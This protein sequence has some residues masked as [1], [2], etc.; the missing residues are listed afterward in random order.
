M[1]VLRGR[2]LRP[3]HR[4]P[5]P[6]GGWH[7]TPAGALQPESGFAGAKLHFVQIGLGTFGTFIQNLVGRKDEWDTAIGWLLEAVS[8]TRPRHFLGAAVEPVPEH[9]ERLRWQA[10]HRL[11]GLR[12]VQAAI[13]DEEG[14]MELTVLTQAAHDKALASAPRQSRAEVEQT[15]LYL[16]NMSHLTG[17]DNGWHYIVDRAWRDWGADVQPETLRTEVWSYR[18]LAKSLD[19]CG[20][21]VLAIDAEGYDTKILR[22]VVKHCVEEEMRGRCAWPDLITFE[23]AGHCDSI[24]GKGAEAAAIKQLELCGYTN[25]THNH[26]NTYMVRLQA[27]AQSWP[28]HRWLGKMACSACGGQYWPIRY[29]SG[30]PLCSWCS[31]P[32]GETA[33]ETADHDVSAGPTMPPTP[34]SDNPPLTPYQHKLRMQG[35]R[36]AKKPRTDG[37]DGWWA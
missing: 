29:D 35:G 11:P 23:S 7:S 19:F 9:A 3:S 6:G 17:C 27:V 24:E 2:G 37:D 14:S 36:R 26:T 33:G 18:R 28:L 22:S 30:K 20:C 4:A 15:L 13:G 1:P 21:E 12:L 5:C 32:A 8:E 10:A 34:P 31:P 16:R 25:V